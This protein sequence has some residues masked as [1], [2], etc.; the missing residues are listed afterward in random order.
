MLVPLVAALALGCG[1]PDAAY[2]QGVLDELP[3]PSSWELVQTVVRAPGAELN[4]SPI[5]NDP[6]PSVLRYYLVDGQPTDAYPPAKQMLE[7]A[8][9]AIEEEFD[10]ECD[11]PNAVACVVVAARAEEQLR[12]NLYYP[13]EDQDG[14]GLAKEGRTLIRITASGKV[15]GT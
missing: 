3:V 9:F 5:V 11:S 6:C 13:G 14:L 4:C 7:A 8:G 15:G 10:P 1:G 2:Y 12:V